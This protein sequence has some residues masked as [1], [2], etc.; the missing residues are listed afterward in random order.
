MI[1]T[2]ATSHVIKTNQSPYEPRASRLH[3]MGHDKMWDIHTPIYSGRL[4]HLIAP[5]RYHPVLHFVGRSALQQWDQTIHTLWSVG[6][7]LYALELG[8]DRR[9]TTRGSMEV[10]L[11]FSHPGDKCTTILAVQTLCSP[12]SI[13]GAHLAPDDLI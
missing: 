1:Y 12:P 5:H 11:I 10:W 4:S 3:M 13:I 9:A 7:A 8:V 2:A 6:V